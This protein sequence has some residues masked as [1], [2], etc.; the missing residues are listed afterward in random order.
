VLRTD[1]TFRIRARSTFGVQSLDIPDSTTELSKFIS[2]VSSVTHLESLLLASQATT[3][4]ANPNPTGNGQLIEV[5]TT[6][7]L[8]TPNTSTVSAVYSSYEI[9]NPKQLLLYEG[10]FMTPARFL[11]KISSSNFT[12][13]G[14][15]S[16]I[17]SN[18]NYSYS[19]FKFER[20]NLI[21]SAN[22]YRQFI[23]SFGSNNNITYSALNNGDVMIRIQAIRRTINVDNYIRYTDSNTSVE[24]TWPLY[25]PTTSAT[26]ATIDNEN[27]SIDYNDG[28]GNMNM[29]SDIFNN[30]GNG[31]ANKTGTFYET[32]IKNL[33]GVYYSSGN[34]AAQS[35]T[36][37]MIFYVAIGIRNNKDIYFDKITS[38][39]I[40][41]D[42]STVSR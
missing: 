11:T 10:V 4:P 16:S 28:L 15:P 27:A 9:Y 3:V 41:T 29:T 36:D 42:T 33:S 30:A 1:I 23:M 26:T 7:D 12:K 35:E 37:F 14:I 38:F 13:Y 22:R 25:K 2:D 17:S 5:P 34:I 31:I 39:D 6:F 8:T 40:V 32:S 20:R 18:A 24:Y 21:S 19:I